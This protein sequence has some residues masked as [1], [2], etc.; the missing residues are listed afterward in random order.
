MFYF[1]INTAILPPMIRTEDNLYIRIIICDNNNNN[2]RYKLFALGK[3]LRC[4]GSGRAVCVLNASFV[5]L[6]QARE[7]RQRSLCAVRDHRIFMLASWRWSWRCFFTMLK[8]ERSRT[9]GQGGIF[10]STLVQQSYRYGA[11]RSPALAEPETRVHCTAS[12]G[13]ERRWKREEVLTHSSQW[14]NSAVWGRTPL[15]REQGIFSRR[16]TK[17]NLG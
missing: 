16:C 17:V 1:L 9:S 10:S 8:L 14:D 2:G 6:C 5:Q 13:G 3:A 12:T 15:Q 4:I 7:D 11:L